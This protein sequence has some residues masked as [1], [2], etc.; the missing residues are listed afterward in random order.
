MAGEARMPRPDEGMIHAWLDGELSPEESAH[1]A[2]LAEADPAWRAAVAEARG[3]IAASSRIVRALDA[4][5]GGV[6]PAKAPRARPAFRVRPWVGIAAG[7]V[8]VAGTAYVMRDATD[9]AFSP[10]ARPAESAAPPAVNAAPP[11][12]PASAPLTGGDGDAASTAAVSPPTQVP[13]PTASKAASGAGALSRDAAQ[14]PSAGVASGSGAPRELA[15]TA[16]VDSAAGALRREAEE[17]RDQ[18]RAAAPV[19]ALAAPPAAASAGERVGETGAAAQRLRVDADRAASRAARSA[20]LTEAAAAPAA[21]PPRVLEG[22]WLATAPTELARLHR[23]LV[24]VR[25]AGDS[26]ELRISP[27][28]TVVVLRDGELLRGGLTARRTE[29]PAAP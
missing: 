21:P 5:P 10:A 17:L 24:I 13:A 29:C 14:A 2:Q 20:A 16:S 4:V 25:V 11:G 15:A 1:V 12:P 18:A 8:F 6:V 22:C 3:L 23:D 7:L 9:A 28:A 27:T 19:T 26:L